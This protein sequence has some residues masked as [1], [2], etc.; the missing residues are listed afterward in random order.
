MGKAFQDYRLRKKRIMP[1][2]H[3]IN[4]P[5]RVEVR[6]DGGSSNEQRRVI[7]GGKGLIFKKG[8]GAERPEQTKPMAQ[9][10]ATRTLYKGRL[11]G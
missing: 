1:T 4:I 6:V 9:I 7:T 5:Q 11:M 3:G 10:I 2:S 8:S